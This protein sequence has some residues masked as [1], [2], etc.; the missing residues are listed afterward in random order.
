MTTHT[1]TMTIPV[2]VQGVLTDV[3]IRVYL[4]QEQH[5]VVFHEVAIKLLGC[6]ERADRPGLVQKPEETYKLLGP[7]RVR[8]RTPLAG[9]EIRATILYTGQQ[10]A[11]HLMLSFTQL[12]QAVNGENKRTPQERQQLVHALAPQLDYTGHVLRQDFIKVFKDAAPYQ[13]RLLKALSDHLHEDGNEKLLAQCTQALMYRGR[14]NAK[15]F[16]EL[17]PGAANLTNK[18][19]KESDLRVDLVWQIVL[20]VAEPDAALRTVQE[21]VDVRGAA[22]SKEQLLSDVLQACP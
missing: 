7:G 13:Q 19:R 9:G 15:T 11:E 6:A 20:S 14:R 16:L 18:D 4:V 3:T 5:L 12:L 2:V 1:T 22:P 10:P 21:K 8:V 17:L